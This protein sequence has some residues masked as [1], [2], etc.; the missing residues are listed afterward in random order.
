[1]SGPIQKTYGMNNQSPV[2][3]RLDDPEIILLPCRL[4]NLVKRSGHSLV[5][6]P[7]ASVWA[8]V[9]SWP[10]ED[11]WSPMDDRRWRTRNSTCCKFRKLSFPSPFFDHC[12]RLLP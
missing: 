7:S 11:P 2:P 8:V 6:Q 9:V 5:N 3:S 10:T 1:M 12:F 4:D